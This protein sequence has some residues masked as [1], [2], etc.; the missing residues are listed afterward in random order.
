MREGGQNLEE[1]VR[2]LEAG[3]EGQ[4]RELERLRLS[5]AFPRKTRVP[6]R[7]GT[8]PG[9]AGAGAYRG[10][11]VV[12]TGSGRPEGRGATGRSLGDRWRGLEVPFELANLRRW[13]WWM[14]KVGI[15]LFLLGVVF[16][17][18]FSWDRGWLQV[19]LT[20]AVRVGIGVSLGTALVWVGLRVYARRR[21]FA[22]VLLGGGIGTYYITG[23]AAYTMLGVV[24]YLVAFAFMAAV[25][26]LAF[27]L[28]LHQNGAALSVIGVS[29]GLA[30]PFLL[31][32]GSG[33]LGG[34][35]VYAGLVLFGAMGIYLLKGWRSLLV[36]AFGGYWAV[37]LTGRAGVDPVGMLPAADSVALQ[38]GVLYGWVLPW[39]VPCAREAL[40]SARPGRWRTPE[41]GAAMRRLTGGRESLFEDGTLTVGISFASPLAA[42]WTTEVVW[43]PERDVLGLVALGISAGHALAW[44][45]LRR[46]GGADRL[47]HAQALVSLLFATF[48]LAFLLEGEA[49]LLA[50]AVEGAALHFVARK[51]SDRAVSLVGHALFAVVAA[52]VF[53]LLAEGTL[54]NIFDPASGYPFFDAYALA[55][56]AVV[57]LAFAASAA[58]GTPESR[59]VYRTLGHA[60]AAGLLLRELV[61]LADGFY[62]LVA[63]ALYAAGLH[64][65]SRRR[66]GWGT[67]GGA[68]ALTAFVG[69]WLAGRLAFG[70]VF[71]DGFGRSLLGPW[72]LWGIADLT[73]VA[74]IA[75]CS[76]AVAGRK[77]ALL[78]RVAAHVALLAWLWR[79]FGTLPGSP[80][81]YVTVAWGLTGAALFVAGLRRDHTHLIKGGVATLFLVVAKLFLWD[82]AELDPLWRVLLFLGFGGLFLLLSYH[83][84]NLWSP[85][86]DGSAPRVSDDQLSRP[87]R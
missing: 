82:L 47:S 19:L 36:V 42:L 22:Q 38:A 86:G 31:Y 17:F 7:A 35:V 1:R 4:E 83:L 30:T 67:T 40:C 24:S 25:T 54:V 2:R 71:P 79:E 87:A 12:V 44:A 32:D 34:L 78:Y 10:G 84:R 77:T 69:L 15:A 48:S 28:A 8:G 6:D 50:L 14:N 73:V 43:S 27:A 59:R 65:L 11:T 52:W 53:P 37:L 33:A 26:L 51:L 76:W 70:I 63:L 58:L 74:L 29:G 60:A 61:P 81:A 85:R 21:A 45:G 20:P 46:V 66:P 3:F 80:D 62:A 13:E 49:L 41:A 23:F 16:L 56:L 68:H 57:A 75:A 55:G 72:G 9:T 64:V 39:L 18:K 5:L